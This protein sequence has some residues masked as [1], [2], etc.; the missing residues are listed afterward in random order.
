MIHGLICSY[1]YEHMRHFD[2]VHHR[3]CVMSVAAFV[4]SYSIIV[5]GTCSFSQAALILLLLT[6]LEHFSASL[7]SVL[8]FIL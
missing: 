3:A 2:K 4:F 5:L 7:F 8:T 1:V 6:Q